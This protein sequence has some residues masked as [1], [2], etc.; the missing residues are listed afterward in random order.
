M[1]KGIWYAIAAYG[2]WGLF[3]LYWKPLH[4]VPALELI[5]HRIGWSFVLLF[6][7]ILLTRQWPAFRAVAFEART[8]RIYSVAAVLI[9]VNWTTYVWAVNHGYVVE[10]SLGYFINPL[11]SVVLG[12]VFLH[13]RLRPWQWLPV[14][15]AALGVL[16]VAHAYGFI[17]WLALTMAGSFGLYGLVKKTG[18]LNSFYGLTLETGILF[19]PAL[20]Y[21]LYLE[22]A[23]QGAFLHAGM[24]SNW[25][26]VGAGLVTTVPLLLFSSA[27]QRIPLAVIGILQ[28]ITPTMLFLLGVFV[29][30]EAFT[31]AQ[32]AGFGL[33]WVALIVF[34]VEG[35]LARNLTRQPA[36]TVA[37]L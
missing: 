11:L 31:T 36:P 2:I 1:N 20:G 21:L 37:E 27:A 16:V 35:F 7:I 29:Y 34:S 10:S 23:G 14:G 9:S 6:V 5:G 22:R 32:L 17:P 30:K 12:V 4:Q 13:E 24:L 3:P 8:L 28:Y 18:P 15:L 19:V 25:L 26:M 33:V